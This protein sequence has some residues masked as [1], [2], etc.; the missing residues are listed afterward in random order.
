MRPWRRGLREGRSLV[1]LGSVP[2]SHDRGLQGLK[3][4]RLK[5]KCVSIGLRPYEN[6][7]EAYGNKLLAV[8]IYSASPQAFT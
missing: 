4:P 5:I 7:L 8:A 3:I 2:E 6:F 1:C